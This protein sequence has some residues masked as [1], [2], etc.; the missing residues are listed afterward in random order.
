MTATQNTAAWGGQHRVAGYAAVAIAGLMAATV[1]LAITARP[2]IE[3]TVTSIPTQGSGVHAAKAADLDAA[4]AD[5]TVRDH[6]AKA[7]D[8]DAGLSG[9]MVRDH[10]AKAADLDAGLSGLMVRDQ[11]GSYV[12]AI[13]EKAP[14]AVVITG[15]DQFNAYMDSL[16]RK[17]AERP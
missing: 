11:S 8:L 13:P 4:L 7:A 14:A 2:I 6:A 9:L 5:L 17:A 12:P 16:L 15:T 1:G 10:A 3:S